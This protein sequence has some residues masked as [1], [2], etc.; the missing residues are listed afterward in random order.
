MENIREYLK[1][2]Y[3]ALIIKTFEETRV[4]KELIRIGKGLELNCKVWSITKGWV[5]QI[6]NQSQE[7]YD[8]VS[9]LQAIV[10]NDDFCIYVLQNYHHYIDNPEVQQLIKDLIPIAKEKA[11]YIVFVSAKFDLPTEIEKEVTVIDYQFPSFD[12][13]NDVLNV[14]INSLGEESEITRISNSIADRKKLVESAQG[15]T[16]AEAE[17][18]FA[19]ALVRHKEFNHE[20]IETVQ[21]EKANIIKKTGI[22]EYIPP[23]FSL[24]D[25]GGLAQ[26][27][28]W[29]KHRQRAFSDAA[30]AYGLPSPR[31]VLLVGVP[32]AGKSLTAKAVSASW[33]LPL[34]RFDV[35][36][37][38]GSLVGQSE[39]QMRKALQTAE[40]IAPCILWLDEIE[41]GMAGLGSSGSTDSGTTARVFGTFL[42]WM[43]EKEKPVFVFA[44][45]NNVSS[46][47]PEMLRKG[48][49]DELFFVDLPNQQ[50]R[51]EIF[52]IHLSKRNRC[53]A[54]SDIV[55]LAKAAEG[56]G[57]SEIEESVISGMY[58]AFGE[59]RELTPDDVLQAL[60]ETK[61]LSE[62]MKEDIERIRNWANSRARNASAQYIESVEGS[63]R[64]LTI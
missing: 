42:T 59:G 45:A 48:R 32:G 14:V 36:K 49:F 17:N 11:R 60:K 51:E 62:T 50:E 63:K 24:D 57:G 54:D 56:Y 31:G 35:G 8:P 39:E 3:P 52:R 44:T 26:L 40:A 46:L 30:R 12:E 28:Q 64:R 19:L 23:K 34:L 18:A 7:A 38:F 4:I 47:P 61:P 9:A 20:A 13:L 1:A 43:Q 58:K 53:F 15:L 37:V 27:K 25:I 33:K 22:L 5:D 16:C 2:G 21:K 10:N 6:T 29:L 41:K 55:T